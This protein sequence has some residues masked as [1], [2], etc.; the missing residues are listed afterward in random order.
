MRRPWLSIAV[1][2]VILTALG[3]FAVWTWSM[4]PTGYSREA[5]IVDDAYVLLLA[6][7]VP[8]F[9][10]V[11]AMLVYSAVRFRTK[12]PPTED[13]P[14]MTGSSR[15][16]AIWLVVTGLLALVILVNPGIVGLANLRANQTADLVIDVQAQRWSWNITYPNGGTTSEELVVP[17]DVRV[18]FDVTSLDILHSFWVPAFRAK[19][20]AVPG[21]TT[22]LYLTPDRAGSSVDDPTLRLQ[23][24][25][26]CGLGHAQMV[27]QVRVV[28]EAEFDAWVSG[29]EGATAAEEGA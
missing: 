6:L 13:G 7:A 4:L 11:I 22:Q 23:C 1:L 15:I 16:V 21:R 20:D 18:R 29:L 28:S 17:V 27:I 12:G 3:E 10:F 14:P 24:A 9:A 19:I 26:L 2:S 5:E 8:V 25:E